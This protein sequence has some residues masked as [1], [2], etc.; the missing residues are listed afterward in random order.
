MASSRFNVVIVGGGVAGLVAASR[1]SEDNKTKV[2]V[3]EAGPDLRGDQNIDTPGLLLNTWGNPYYDWDFWSVP[4]V[5]R[6]EFQYLYCT[7]SCFKE[8]CIDGLK[9]CEVVPQRKGNSP[10]QRQSAW[11]L[12]SH[13]RHRSLVSS[14]P[15]LRD[16]DQLGQQRLDCQGNDALLPKVHDLSRTL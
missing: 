4:Q 5:R 9:P 11:W 2:L 14:I 6:F 15:R 1:L 12:F 16:V 3:V 7:L 8:D 13:Q 10:V